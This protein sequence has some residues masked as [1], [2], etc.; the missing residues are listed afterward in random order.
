MA[1]FTAMVLGFCVSGAWCLRRAFSDAIRNQ[2]ALHWPAL[3]GIVTESS[4]I[5]KSYGNPNTRTMYAPQVNVRYQ[6]EGQSY[7]CQTLYFGY[8]TTSNRGSIEADLATFRPGQD[9]TVYYNPRDPSESV[10][11][12]GFKGA[13][14]TFIIVGTVLLGFGLLIGVPYFFSRPEQNEEEEAVLDKAA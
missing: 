8:G 3:K 12:P 13:N 14:F 1:M 11:S 2:A 9:A 10:L 5:T 7:S 6:F 4:V